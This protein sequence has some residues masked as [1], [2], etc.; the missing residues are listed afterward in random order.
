[1]KHVKP[2]SAAVLSAIAVALAPAAAQA[3]SMCTLPSTANGGAYT[4]MSMLLS[5][6]PLTI[7]GGLVYYVWK[8]YS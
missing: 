6:L 7:V 2:D 8:R 4:G 1:M 5:I 3:C